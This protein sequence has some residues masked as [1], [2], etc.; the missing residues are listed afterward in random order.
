MVVS[1]PRWGAPEIWRRRAP[2]A[3]LRPVRE[4]KFDP[5]GGTLAVEIVV[6]GGQPGDMKF[7]VQV[8]C[9]QIRSPVQREE[10]TRFYKE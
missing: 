2:G 5:R 1:S 7:K 9:D 10:N 8:A 6:K 4:V 3:T